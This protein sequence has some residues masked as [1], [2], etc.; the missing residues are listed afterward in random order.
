MH[1]EPWLHEISISKT[2]G[3]HFWL[4]P[5]I[6]NLEGGEGGGY[7]HFINW[8]G[9]QRRGQLVNET[10]QIL[11]LRRIQIGPGGGPGERG[12]VGDKS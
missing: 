5:P 8:V 9:K 3:H 1:A 2:V 6:I 11:D 4:V 10:K 12:G 7:L